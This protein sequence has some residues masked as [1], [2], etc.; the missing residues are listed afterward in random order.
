MNC[1]NHRER[2]ALALCK[3]CAKALCE[4]CLADGGNGVACH[5]ACEERVRVMNRIVDHHGTVL[6][7]ANT[8]MRAQGATV[9]ALG[10][11]LLGLAV[12]GWVAPVPIFFWMGLIAGTIFIAFGARLL[13]QKSRYP[14]AE[15]RG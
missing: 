3:S 10:L 14:V 9:F 11:G 7:T 4:E 15:E 6:S 2:V 8:Q 12:Y 13:R 5:G 1:F